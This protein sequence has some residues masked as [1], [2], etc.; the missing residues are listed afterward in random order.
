MYKHLRPGRVP[1]AQVIGGRV[2]AVPIVTRQSESATAKERAGQIYARFYIISMYVYIFFMLTEL[3]VTLSFHVKENGLL[4]AAYQANIK[5][6][7]H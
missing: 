1:K 5:M 4:T 2:K 6:I 3:I 7:N